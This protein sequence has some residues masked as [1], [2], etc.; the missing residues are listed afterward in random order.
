MLMCLPI[1]FIK[2]YFRSTIR[3]SNGLDQ[4]QHSVGPELGLNCLQRLTADKDAATCSKQRVNV[5][6][7][8]ENKSKAILTIVVLYFEAD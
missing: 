6:R 8:S 1:F 7:K 3:V 4:D 5:I 2:I